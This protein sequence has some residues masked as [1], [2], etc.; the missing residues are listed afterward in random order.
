VICDWGVA[1][2]MKNA[3][4]SE[5]YPF[6]DDGNREF[7]FAG[8]PFAARDPN[9]FAF[10]RPMQAGFMY[11]RWDLEWRDE[12]VAAIRDVVTSFDEVKREL[13]WRTPS[14]SAAWLQVQDDLR[15]YGIEPIGLADIQKLIGVELPINGDPDADQKVRPFPKR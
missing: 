1:Y 14:F 11:P 3:K 7:V 8:D 12:V 10:R 2:Q 15:R 13:G 9:V 5:V 6:Q 4:P